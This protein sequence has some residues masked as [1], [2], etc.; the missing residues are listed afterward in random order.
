MQAPSFV[1][2]LSTWAVPPKNP[3]ELRAL[4]LKKYRADRVAVHPATQNEMRSKKSRQN[5]RSSGQNE[6]SSYKRRRKSVSR[7]LRKK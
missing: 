5:K 2:G 6:R 1:R 7:R 3:E 4:R